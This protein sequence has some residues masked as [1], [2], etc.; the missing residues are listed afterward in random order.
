M[1]NSSNSPTVPTVVN[2]PRQNQNVA[3][4]TPHLSQN[5][6]TNT[7]HQNQNVPTPTIRLVHRRLA[8]QARIRHLD[9]SRKVLLETRTFLIKEIARLEARLK[10]VE[11][12]PHIS[13]CQLSDDSFSSHPIHK[14]IS[15]LIFSL[16]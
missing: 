3:T 14:M 9:H 8:A 7:P 16:F 12:S 15:I 2:T 1:D 6:V 13:Y 10:E 11:V 4:N 5:V